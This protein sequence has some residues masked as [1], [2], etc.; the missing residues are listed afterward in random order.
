[1]MLCTDTDQYT[2][3]GDKIDTH[4]GAIFCDMEAA[5]EYAEDAVANNLCTR[6]T[7]GRFVLDPLSEKTYISEIETFGFR[8]DKKNINQLKLFK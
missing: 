5:K 4:D 7:I 1:M 2:A 3:G 6:F 8:K